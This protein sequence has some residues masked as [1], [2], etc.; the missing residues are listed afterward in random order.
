[1][2]LRPLTLA[3]GLLLLSA[4]SSNMS[5]QGVNLGK[6]YDA[7]EKVDDLRDRTL[8]EE[9]LIGAEVAEQ[10]LAE[11]RLLANEPVQ[12][13]V[14]QVGAW[15]ALNSE[16]PELRWRFIV[17]DD[18]SFNAFA[19]PSGYVF[20]TSGTLARLDNEAELAGILAHEMSHVLHRHYLQALQQEATVGILSDLTA[21]AVEFAQARDGSYREGRES[22]VSAEGLQ[23]KVSDLYY[24]GLERGDEL[25]A[26]AMAVVLAARAGYDPHAY[27]SVLQKID[28]EQGGNPGWTDFFRKHP[29]PGERIEQ[30]TP[31]LERA[32]ARESGYRLL[33]ERYLEQAQ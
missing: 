28:Q 27:M 22:G 25:E 32:F 31:E 11:S 16:R 30:L 12:R 13:Y 20:V 23:G 26:D 1:M 29:A 8:E 19:A 2:N 3:C 6:L 10:L 14:N 17:L 5:I 21:A 9:A 15:L 4:C 24:K 18:A 33:A 7:G